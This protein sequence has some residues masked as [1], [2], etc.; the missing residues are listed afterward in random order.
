MVKKGE[1]VNEPLRDTPSRV[2][3]A[4]GLLPA[5]AL[6]AVVAA[7]VGLQPAMIL[8]GTYVGTYFSGW[9]TALRLVDRLQRDALEVL[10]RNDKR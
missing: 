3:E 9:L 7:L 6:V 4:I 10:R 1:E 2:F 8:I 5:V